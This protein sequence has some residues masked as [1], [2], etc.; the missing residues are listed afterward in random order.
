[1]R[2]KVI[3]LEEQPKSTQGNISNESFLKSKIQYLESELEKKV[4][5][6]DQLEG[7]LSQV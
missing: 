5:N 6:I 2:S 4:D 7:R 1:M 3:M